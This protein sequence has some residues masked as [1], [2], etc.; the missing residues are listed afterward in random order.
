MRF[1]WK[2]H[3]LLLVYDIYFYF[4]GIPNHISVQFSAS[5]MFHTGSYI[6]ATFVSQDLS[7]PLW[8]RHLGDHR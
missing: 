4:F 3:N 2:G 1:M 8:P 7:G 6:A 5:V